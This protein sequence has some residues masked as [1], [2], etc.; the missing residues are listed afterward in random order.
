[1][2]EQNHDNNITKIYLY[3]YKIYEIYSIIKHVAM[4]FLPEIKYLVSCRLLCKTQT[5]SYINNVI[6]HVAMGIL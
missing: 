4:D 5:L 1:M 3:I 2:D 6:K